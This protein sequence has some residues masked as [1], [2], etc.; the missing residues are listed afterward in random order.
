MRWVLPAAMLGPQGWQGPPV[1]APLGLALHSSLEP[2]PQTWQPTACSSHGKG[3]A[4][5][6]SRLLFSRLTKQLSAAAQAGW[7]DLQAGRDPMWAWRA[8]QL[9]LCSCSRPVQ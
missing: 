2:Q 3:G 7:V 1:L 9:V 8:K 4:A 5:A 6:C